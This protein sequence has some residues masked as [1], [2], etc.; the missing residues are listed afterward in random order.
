VKVVEFLELPKSKMW[1][2]GKMLCLRENLCG[3]Q[4]DDFHF[5]AILYCGFAGFK[6]FLRGCFRAIE[7]AVSN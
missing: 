5:S 4:S 1:V 7:N 6:H 2:N 3:F